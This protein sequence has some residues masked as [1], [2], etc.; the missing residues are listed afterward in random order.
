[1]WRFRRALAIAALVCAG[2]MPTACGSA[3]RHP[4]T[5]SDVSAISAAVSDIVYQCQSVGAG[6]VA[7][8]DT[9]SLAHDVTVLV[10]ADRRVR[11]DAGFVLGTGSGIRRRTSLR[12][13][14]VLA[15]QVM[16]QS[17]CLPAQA[18]RL[19]ATGGR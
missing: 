10:D 6:F 16:A 14:I 2:L 9:P 8:P 1:M 3:A 11:P 19:P 15:A 5:P 17:G 7:A 13:E 18:R 12:S 4:P